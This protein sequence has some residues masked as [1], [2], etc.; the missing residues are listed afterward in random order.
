MTTDATLLDQLL[1]QHG[2]R[3]FGL[4]ARL[5]PDPGDAYGAVCERLWRQIARFDRRRGTLAAWSTTVAHRVLVDR[6]RRRRTVVPLSGQECANDSVE[7]T[8]Q[9]RRRKDRLEVALAELPPD[10]RRVVVLHHLEGHTLHDIAQ[11][12]GVALGTVKSRLHRGRASLAVA[13]QEDR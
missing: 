2:D 8:V 1:A 10:Q 6:H 12:E 9:S 7:R 11:V 5:D 4:C 13:L 3:L